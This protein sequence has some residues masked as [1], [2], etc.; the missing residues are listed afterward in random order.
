[1]KVNTSKTLIILRKFPQQFS[2][3][4]WKNLPLHLLRYPLFFIRAFQN[5]LYLFS[6]SNR[7]EVKGYIGKNLWTYC[8]CCQKSV[9][10]V[11]FYVI[12]LDVFAI[13]MIISKSVKKIK[14]LYHLF[15]CIY[16]FLNNFKT[17]QKQYKDY[18]KFM[19]SLKEV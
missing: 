15:W 12:L 4:K 13:F 6:S 18:C 3:W 11:I 17:M 1:M 10:S 14:F 16:N 8:R 5:C 9:L 19:Y 7:A 2:P